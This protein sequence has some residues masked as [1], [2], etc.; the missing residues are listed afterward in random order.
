MKICCY[1]CLMMNCFLKRKKKSAKGL[2]NSRLM[3]KRRMMNG[4]ERSM[5][6]FLH[7]SGMEPM[8]YNFFV[9][10]FVE[11]LPADGAV[12]CLNCIAAGEHFVVGLLPFSADCCL[13]YTVSAAHSAEEL[14]H[15][16]RVVRPVVE[17]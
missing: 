1:R 13:D 6:F 10:A 12:H 9:V 8:E 16:E 5:C 3:M 17:D 4:P 11:V 14:L 7:L 2:N 15:A